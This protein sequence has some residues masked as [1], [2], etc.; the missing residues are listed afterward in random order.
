[1]YPSVY[2]IRGTSIFPSVVGAGVRTPYSWLPIPFSSYDGFLLRGRCGSL[3]TDVVDA[4]CA[5][6]SLVPML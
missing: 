6:A 1:M 3:G 5:I 2:D 4:L